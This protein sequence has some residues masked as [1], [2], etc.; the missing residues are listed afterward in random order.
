MRRLGYLLLLVFGVALFAAGWVAWFAL[1]PLAPVT[2]PVEVS[3]RPGMTF[4]EVAREVSRAGAGF[5][6]WAF[7][8]LGRILRA[9]RRV[10]AGSYVFPSG[11]SAW[12]VL[13]MLMR[14]DVLFAELRLIEGWPFRQLRAEL[15]R[16]PDLVHASAGLTDEDIL[17]RIGASEPHPEGLFFP[18]TYRVARGTSDLE[19][20]A[21]AYRAMQRH[22]AREWA[23][24]D[25]S[26]PLRDAYQALILASI[27]EKES[28]HDEDRARIAAVFLN[29]LARGMPLQ[30]DPSVIYGLGA[31]FDG[32]LR[33]RD[34]VRDGDYNTYTRVGLPPTPI[35]ATGLAALRAVLHPPR[36]DELYFVARGDG[37]SEFSRTLSEHNRA[38]ARYQ[39]RADR[40]GGG[41]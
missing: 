37:R 33:R 27:V 26:L 31:G 7:E 36:T 2:S 12:D 3:V 17:R 39:L 6:A 28:G 19:L 11:V 41:R 22:L 38:V 25:P 5:D 24:R 32:N 23:A 16:H 30:T 34:L 8:L 15:D 20:L 4:K 21:R 1:R 9:E 13:D 35:S 40:S 10:Q 29:R 14:G 18:D